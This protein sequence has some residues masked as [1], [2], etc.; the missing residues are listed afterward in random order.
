MKKTK[1]YNNL[2]DKLLKKML[3]KPGERVVYK[4]Y[5]ITS[6]PMDPTRLAIPAYRN[7]P[8]IDQIYDKE[9]ESYIDIAAVKSVDAEGN[10]TFHDIYFTSQQAG[11]MILFGGRA[12]DQEIHSYLSLCNHNASNKD[13]DTTKEVIFELV[14]EEAK[15]EKESTTRN[16]KR[17]A[18]NIAAD[19]TPE[20]VKDYTAA[21]GKSEDRPIKVLRNELE[22]LADRDPEEFLGLINNKQAVMKATINRALA[23]GAILF[24][25]EQSMYKWANGEAILTVARGTEAIDEFVSF[26][27]SSAKGEKVYQNLQSKSKK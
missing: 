6:A 9:S 14:D 25:E 20:D 13:R 1:L 18:L 26:C 23:K 19:L 17:D 8:P 2:P 22:A 15:A 4:L 3:L 24:S 27:V 5:N 21:L 11:H 16:K 12:V 10:H 7:V